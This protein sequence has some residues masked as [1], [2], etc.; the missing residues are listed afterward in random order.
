MR[1]MFIDLHEVL[2]RAPPP[3]GAGAAPQD[4]AAAVMQRLNALYKDL[5]AAVKEEALLME[6]IFPDPA[7]ALAAFTSRV[8]EQKIKARPCVDQFGFGSP[9]G[10][11]AT[12]GR[13]GS[14]VTVP[15]VC[16]YADQLYSRDRRVAT[17]VA[18]A[19]QLTRRCIL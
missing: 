1:P 18:C 9:S 5:L 12:G 13:K 7:S 19:A 4:T 8:F 15:S 17:R 11:V 3:P 10:S 14:S 2:G 6:Q 16:L